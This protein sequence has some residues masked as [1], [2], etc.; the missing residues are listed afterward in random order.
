MAEQLEIETGYFSHELQAGASEANI[1]L[2]VVSNPVCGPC[3]FTHAAIEDL[4]ERFEGKINVVFRFSINPSDTKSESFEM[5]NHLVALQ[6]SKSKE[7]S[8]KA[9]SSWYLK[10]GKN[11][12]KKWKGENPISTNH[13][14]DAITTQ[15][16]EHAKWC[17]AAGI[18]VTPT[19][20]IN[21]KKL[22]E[23]YSVVDL[24]YQIRKL[25]QKEVTAL[26]P[27]S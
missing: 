11:N 17:A 27:V 10:N 25:L 13:S 24:K 23:E 12:I 21:G 22:P 9:L 3:A 18:K 8:I 26:E 19:I 7:E 5:L 2:T 15:I 16:N 4:L 6:L 20:L 14:Q 1:T